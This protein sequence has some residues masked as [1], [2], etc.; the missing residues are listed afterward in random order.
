M[1]R[2]CSLILD[3]CMASN[4]LVQICRIEDFVHMI[5]FFFLNK[6]WV[7]KLLNWE[8]NPGYVTAKF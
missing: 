7:N 2:K 1:N 8:Q 3:T 6:N 4:P 5:L